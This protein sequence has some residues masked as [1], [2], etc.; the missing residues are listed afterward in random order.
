MSVSRPSGLWSPS[1]INNET[2]SPDMAAAIGV[3]AVRAIR[4]EPAETP[5]ESRAGQ[6]ALRHR[7]RVLAPI[8]FAA[9]LACTFESTDTGG[10]RAQEM[11]LAQPEGT[12]HEGADAA[13]FSGPSR[14][15]YTNFDALGH[16]I[17]S[18]LSFDGT[19]NYRFLTIV[20]GMPIRGGGNYAAAPISHSSLALQLRPFAWY[21]RQVCSGPFGQGGHCV[22]IMPA[23]GTIYVRFLDR[24]TTRGSNGGTCHRLS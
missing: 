9:A 21:P 20:A 4:A 10:A 13:S 14:W 12:E 18:Y 23:S 7:W 8:F 3:L 24:N 17:S 6:F 16:Q 2:S 19:G 22:P 5:G 11:G 15:R 1:Q